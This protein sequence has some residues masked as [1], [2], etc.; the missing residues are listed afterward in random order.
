MLTHD[1]D[2]ENIPKGNSSILQKRSKLYNINHSI[3]GKGT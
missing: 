2:I 1:R 3:H